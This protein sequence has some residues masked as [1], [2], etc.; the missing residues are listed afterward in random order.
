LS[1]HH[2]YNITFSMTAAVSI[3]ENQ[4]GHC[5]INIHFQAGVPMMIGQPPN[6]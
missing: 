6:Q 3:V 5:Y 2:C 4:L 1:V